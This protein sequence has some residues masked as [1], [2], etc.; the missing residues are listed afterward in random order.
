M[1]GSLICVFGWLR[2]HTH[3]CTLLCAM[4]VHSSAKNLVTLTGD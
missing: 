4:H 3:P 2:S 1:F